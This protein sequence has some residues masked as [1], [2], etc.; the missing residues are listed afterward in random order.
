MT[1][2]EIQDEITE[3]LAVDDWPAI[4]VLITPENVDTVVRCNGTT[5]IDAFQDT[6]S[7]TWLLDRYLTLLSLIEA[8]KAGSGVD[9]VLPLF[10]PYHVLSAQIGQ[11]YDQAYGILYDW[12]D[13]LGYADPTA[14]TE[15]GIV[16]FYATLTSEGQEKNVSPC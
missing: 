3:L 12:F 11:V 2:Q 5:L 16:E 1:F 7:P 15:D 4:A 9:D 6:S 14:E 13:S 8:A 10:V